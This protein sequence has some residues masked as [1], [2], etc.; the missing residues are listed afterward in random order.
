MVEFAGV[1]VPA[2]KAPSTIL[3]LLRNPRLVSIVFPPQNLILRTITSKLCER[4]LNV[5]GF[6]VRE[7]SQVELL[8]RRLH[9][10]ARHDAAV[11]AATVCCC[12]AA[13]EL[14]VLV[15]V[16][17][18]VLGLYLP[19]V[20]KPVPSPYPPQTIISLPVQTAVWRNRAEGA[21]MVLVAVQVL[22]T[23]PLGPC[24]ILG[25]V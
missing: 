1:T 14:V 25:S 15:A 2:V 22:S 23:H 4:T 13:G 20:F 11:S 10:L 17:L 12:R 21:L 5:R 16:Q 9:D 24:D 7:E 8:G 3:P 19:P 18:S 6:P